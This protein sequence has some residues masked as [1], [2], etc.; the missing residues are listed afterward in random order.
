MGVVIVGIFLSIGLVSYSYGYN[1]EYQIIGKQFSKNPLICTYEP[2]LGQDP[3]LK[4]WGVDRL[5]ETARL[6]VQDWQSALQQNE[7]REDRDN[8]RIDY[9]VLTEKNIDAKKDCNVL[10]QFSPMSGN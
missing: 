5:S 2:V 10:I 1:V 6:A 4:Q 7:K 9:L 3:L 8:W